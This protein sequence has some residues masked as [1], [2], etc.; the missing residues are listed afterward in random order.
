MFRIKQIQCFVPVGAKKYLN[1]FVFDIFIFGVGEILAY[2][3][4][5]PYLYPSIYCSTHRHALLLGEVADLR[6]VPP[7]LLP[8]HHAPH[9]PRQDAPSHLLGLKIYLLL[10][11]IFIL[12]F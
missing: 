1:L 12:L 9:Q 7:P 8:G 6:L 4:D 3:K 11:D 2:V 10:L 5:C